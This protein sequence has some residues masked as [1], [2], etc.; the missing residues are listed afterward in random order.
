MNEM[1]DVYSDQTDILLQAEHL[2]EENNT[3]LKLIEENQKI[4]TKES[5]SQNVS[6]FQRLNANLNQVF[7]FFPLILFILKNR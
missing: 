7:S 2:L 6:L 1:Q 4:Q 3:L 5:L